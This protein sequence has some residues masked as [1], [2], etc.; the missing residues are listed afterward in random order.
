MAQNAVVTVKYVPEY[1]VFVDDSDII[2]IEYEYSDVLSLYAAYNVLLLREDDRWQAVKEEY[3]ELL[4]DMKS[5]KSR[6][7]D[8]INNRFST[9]PLTL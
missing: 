5:Y 6:A 1:D 7:I 2:T 4:K 3:K 9:T 8:G